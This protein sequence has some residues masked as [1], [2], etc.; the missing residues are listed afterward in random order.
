VKRGQ[1]WWAELPEPTASEPGFKRPVIILQSD[2]FTNTLLSTVIVVAI[3]SNLCLA[4]APGNVQLSTKNTG[5]SRESVANVSQVITMDKRFL[6]ELIGE[7]NPSTMHQID[8]GIRL[9]LSL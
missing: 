1:I 4:A 2:V 5:L 9:I 3:T 7:I 8:N 6:T